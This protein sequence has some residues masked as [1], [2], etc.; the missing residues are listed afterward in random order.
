[1]KRSDSI[2]HVER[3]VLAT[4]MRRASSLGDIPLLPKHFAA[5]THGEIWEAIILRAE[6]GKAGDAI[7]ITDD[8]ER[9]GRKALSSLALEIGCDMSIPVA[10][11][12]AAPAQAVLEAW[13]DREAIR[14]AVDLREDAGRREEGAVDRAITALMELHSEDRNHEHTAK[15]AMV[16]AWDEVSRAH[17]AGGRIIGVSTGL[18]DLDDSLGG[19]HDSD[20]IVVG[21]RPGIGKTGMLLGM[22]EAGARS[23]PVGLISGEQP[24]DQVGMRWLAAGSRIGLGKLRAGKLFAQEEWQRSLRVVREYGEMPVRI[25]DR[26]SPDISEVVRVAR[27]WKHQFGIRALYV[28]YLQRIEVAAMAKSPKH[29][30]VGYVARALKNLARDLRIPVVALAQVS[31]VAGSE[32]PKMHHLSDSSE[33]EKEA[34][35]I[36]MLWRDMSNP[37]EDYAPAEVIVEKNRHG[38]IGV[39]ECLWHGGSTSYLNAATERDEQAVA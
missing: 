34:D 31:R 6:A 9:A 14:I 24:H 1:M 7:A 17:S 29:E 4:A 19:L 26:S 33:I 32:K 21:A 37:N 38:K 28:D 11:N 35:Q 23:G 25:L 3:Q 8:L 18:T 5:E 12:A 10:S 13:R 36:M 27:R 30:R 20:L 22:T 16:A 15:S 2:L 39:V